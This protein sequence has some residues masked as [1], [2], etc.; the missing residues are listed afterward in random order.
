MVKNYMLK[1]SLAL[2]TAGSFSVLKAQT[3]FTYTGAAQTY[4]VPAGVTSI[5]VECYGAQGGGD[6]GASAGGNGGYVSADLIVTPGQVL[7]VFVGGQGAL[8]TS[9]T[10]YTPGGYNGGGNGIGNTSNYSGSGGGASD[11]RIGGTALTDRYVV[12]GGGGGGVLNGAS[13]VGGNG[14][15]LVG[16]DGII[17]YNGWMCSDLTF[18][19]G[20][21]QSAGGIGGTSTSCMWNGTN[22]SFG[23]GG[24][25]YFDYACGGGGGGWYGGGGAHNGSSGAGGSSYT[26]P[27]A[28]NVVHTQGV[29]SG[30]G[31]VVITVLCTG[32][33][34]TTT[35]SA[36]TICLG[37]SFTVEATSTNGG[38]ITWDNSVLNGVPFTPSAA[39]TIMYTATS[40]AVADCPYSVNIE[41]L[42]APTITALVDNSEICIGSDVT[43]TAT[44]NADSYVWDNGVTDGAPFT[45]S[46]AGT[47][48][49]TLTGT[50]STTLCETDAT[51]DVTVFDLITITVNATDELFGS[52]GQIDIT[53]AGGNPTYTFDWD[54]DGTGDFNDTED[55]TSLDPGT[56]IIVV[57]DASDCASATETIVIGSQLGISEDGSGAILL[58]PNPTNG[59]VTLAV[60]GSFIY[61]VRSIVGEVIYAN[62]GFSSTLIDMSALSS[63]TYFIWVK[64]ETTERMIKLINQ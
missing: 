32:D 8:A 52:D 18:A 19:T 20:G 23:Q 64:T 30:N 44:G 33:Q 25:S 11:V 50:N 4:T 57:E 42:D 37:E 63:G 5:Q 46:A 31:Q 62:Y 2:L 10:V 7:N 49:Y 12:A 6:M 40:T 45:P 21:T 58:Y 39:G 61:E 54:N 29:Q 3:T 16:A 59:N 17:A 48:T 55:L 43:F 22:G 51:V 15:G 47:V 1:I 26:N 38:I 13:A 28:T 35:V 34:L 27:A 36:T 41:V 60:D 14:G 9:N 56:Y 53:V 24:D